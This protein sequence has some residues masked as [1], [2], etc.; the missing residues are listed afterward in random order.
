[1]DVDW[2]G[3]LSPFSVVRCTAAQLGVGLGGSETQRVLTTFSGYGK[4][5]GQRHAERDVHTTQERQGPFCISPM[6]LALL[7]TGYIHVWHC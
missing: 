6:C 4:E 1:M 2:I 3:E 7:K 5:A